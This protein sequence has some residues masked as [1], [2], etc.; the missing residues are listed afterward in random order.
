MELRWT[1]EGVSDIEVLSSRLEGALIVAVDLQ[2]MSPLPGVTQLQGDITDVHFAL[3][4]TLFD[5]RQ[6]RVSDQDGRGGH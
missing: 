3:L 1:S 5:G 2:A 6:A 4:L